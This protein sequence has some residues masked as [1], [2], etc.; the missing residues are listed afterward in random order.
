MPEKNAAPEVG[1]DA[2]AGVVPVKGPSRLPRQAAREGR[3]NVEQ[4]ESGPGATARAWVVRL[5]SGEM[6]EAEL[7]EF[8]AWLGESAVNA[9]AFEDERAFWQ[10][11]APLQ[12]TFERLERAEAPH[13]AV[14]LRPRRR[15][16]R[17]AFAGLAAV[18]A[19][20]LLLAFAPELA[21]ALRADL[22][23]GDGAILSATLSDGSRVTLDRNSAIAVAFDHGQRRVELLE[24]EAFFE[25]ARDPA[26]PFRVTAAGGISEALGTAYAVRLERGGARVAVVEG[27]VAVSIEAA[28]GARRDVTAGEAL[29]YTD[30]GGFSPLAALGG[31]RALA[32]RQGRVV[33]VDRPLPDALAEL[34]R[35][36]PGRILLLA[37]GR[38]ASSVSGV[39][40]L[41]RLDEGLAALAATHGLTAHRL[42]PYLTVLR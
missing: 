18:A 4:E 11:L 33:L 2:L 34:E 6:T 41:D 7:A 19:C 12:A 16:I 3:R 8:Y 1:Q 28:P 27:R 36:H 21:V 32:W 35:Y 15:R 37:G 22:R 38:S 5:A 39:I 24:G 31:D 30:A 42:T 29:R 10:R 14:R 40:D 20:L 23:S 26:R 25:V 13:P 9:Q 17:A